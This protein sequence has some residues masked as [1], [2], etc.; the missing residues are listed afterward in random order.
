MG[1]R[2]LGSLVMTELIERLMLIKLMLIRYMALVNVM[3]DG[4]VMI[5]QSL[6]SSTVTPIV[7]IVMD[8]RPLTVFH[9]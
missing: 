6:T 9:V 2:T 5:V 7:R 1:I 3:R 4:L 8:R